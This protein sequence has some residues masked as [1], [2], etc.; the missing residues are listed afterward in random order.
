MFERADGR[1]PVVD[2]VACHLVTLGASLREIHLVGLQVVAV[3]SGPPSSASGFGVQ[4]L[5]QTLEASLAMFS[6]MWHFV[7]GW[8]EVALFL[9][10][11]LVSLLLLESQTLVFAMLVTCIFAGVLG[12][13]LWIVP[14]EL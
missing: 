9:A 8:H 13:C 1:L 10:T 2:F 11:A 5:C 14:E 6:F 3:V 12:G 7:R 4:E